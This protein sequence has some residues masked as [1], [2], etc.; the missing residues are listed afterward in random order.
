MVSV[1]ST[2]PKMGI[3][4]FG[5]SAVIVTSIESALYSNG[6]GTTLYLI[7]SKLNLAQPNVKT[8]AV[9]NTPMF[10][11]FIY[12]LFVGSGR[13]NTTIFQIKNYKVKIFK[14]LR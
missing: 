5:Y 1:Q 2:R 7:L 3:V 8:E 9:T 6:L 4:F 10:L 11:S 14:L 13:E 12:F